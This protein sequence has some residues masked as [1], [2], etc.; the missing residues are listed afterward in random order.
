[1]RAALGRAA[2]DLTD[3]DLTVADDALDATT[4]PP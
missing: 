4:D 3:D 2:A 1:V